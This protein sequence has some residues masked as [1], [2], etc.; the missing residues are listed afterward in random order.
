[1]SYD[2]RFEY[3]L[4][5]FLFIFYFYLAYFSDTD[6]AVANIVVVVVWWMPLSPPILPFVGYINFAAEIF[7]SAAFCWFH[8]HIIGPG[9]LLIDDTKHCG[10]ERD[11]AH[12]YDNNVSEELEEIERRM[13]E[14]RKSKRY[15]FGSLLVCLFVCL[16]FFLFFYLILVVWLTIRLNVVAI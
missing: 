2:H 9:R 13:K 1:M 7:R 15:L 3:N 10:S 4:Y 6:A 11:E 5:Y 8:C 16:I 12:A 14:R